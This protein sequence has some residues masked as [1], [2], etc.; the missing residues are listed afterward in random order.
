MAAVLNPPVATSLSVLSSRALTKTPEVRLKENV[1]SLGCMVLLLASDGRYH[2]CGNRRT[3]GCFLAYLFDWHSHPC[4]GC[5]AARLASISIFGSNARHAVRPRKDRRDFDLISDALPF[6]GLWYTQV[7][8]AIGYAQSYSRSH[9]C[10]I[11]VYE[12]LAT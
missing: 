6:G 8:H 1:N 12:T 5:K 9:P 10:V 7:S 4:G 3:G 11:R 2:S